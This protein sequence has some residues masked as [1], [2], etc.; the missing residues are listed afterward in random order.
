MIIVTSIVLGACFIADGIITSYLKTPLQR[1]AIKTE[2]SPVEDKEKGN[3]MR[4]AQAINELFKETFKKFGILVI[5][6]LLVNVI[7]Q[8]GQIVVNESGKVI[9]QGKKT[10]R[11]TY[12]TFVT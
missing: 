4:E 7:D 12:F 5:P 10:A 9:N 11:V 3:L 2:N 8:G 1:P 6:A